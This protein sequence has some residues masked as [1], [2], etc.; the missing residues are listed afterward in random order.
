M[1]TIIFSLSFPYFS[2]GG[3]KGVFPPLAIFSAEQ[4]PG[5]S[6]GWY[7]WAVQSQ[8]ETVLASL[9]LFP[10]QLSLTVAAVALGF[11]SHVLNSLVIY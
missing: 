11:W 10:A 5:A 6:V 4:M 1:Q 7:K 8:G 2:F 9:V 3:H